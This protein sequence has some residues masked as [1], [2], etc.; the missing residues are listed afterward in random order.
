M[1]SPLRIAIVRLS[2]L[3]DIV[4][5]TATLP[6][7][8]RHLPS[9][10]IDWFCKHSLQ[11][12]L[13]DNPFL[14]QVIPIH[15]KFSCFFSLISLLRSYNR[16]YN[17]D[18][19]IDLQGR[20]FSGLTSFL[21]NRHTSWGLSYNSL[22]TEKYSAF[23]Y[24]KTVFIPYETHIIQRG[25]QLV[26][27]ALNLPFH[28]PSSPNHSLSKPLLGLP[29]F[30]SSLSF[31]K[32][33]SKKF[34]LIIPGTSQPHKNYPISFW[35]QLLIQLKDFPIFLSHGTPA[36]TQIAQELASH[37]SAR[38]LPSLSLSELKQVVA[39]S[40]LV[41]GGDS[42]PTHLAW[43]LK[44]PSITLFSSTPIQRIQPCTNT[45]IGVAPNQFIS[46]YDRHVSCSSFQL[47]QPSVVSQRARN[48]IG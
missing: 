29:P 23:L 43:A 19:V 30:S 25:L 37:T 41:I 34:I 2:A 4:F 15:K 36:E 21:L 24:K 31:L 33:F 8:K 48:L 26:S 45:N 12:I 27:Q 11:P 9:V 22:L 40:R 32:P 17:Y 13:D 42:G 20:F 18:C 46:P 1:T 14:H 5:A 38:L 47:P 10:Q 39:M 16:L 3:G 6:Y 44:T 28:S 7:I 35:K